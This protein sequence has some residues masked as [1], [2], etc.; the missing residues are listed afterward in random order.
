[1]KQISFLHL[2]PVCLRFL[3]Y[4]PNA[5]NISFCAISTMIRS[6]PETY[7]FCAISTMIKDKI[8]SGAINFRGNDRLWKDK[9]SGT[10]LYLE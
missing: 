4:Y 7:R 1:M 6:L 2:R 8:V 9:E 5:W 3:N 10:E